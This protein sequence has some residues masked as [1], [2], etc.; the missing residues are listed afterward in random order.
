MVL[1]RFLPSDFLLSTFLA[2]EMGYLPHRAA[3]SYL[4]SPPLLAQGPPMS[5]ESS[6]HLIGIFIPT[7]RPPQS[8]RARWA[9]WRA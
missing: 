3:P 2:Q 7:L 5:A 6:S 1:F 8:P 9:G 4:M